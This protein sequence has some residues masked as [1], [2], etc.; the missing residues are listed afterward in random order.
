MGYDL[1]FEYSL[2]DIRAAHA[3]F[4]K[5]LFGF[6]W[7]VV[8]FVQ[9]FLF[10]SGVV[11]GVGVG[12]ALILGPLFDN[13]QAATL[14]STLFA[15]MF[16]YVVL[17]LNRLRMNH[18]FKYGLRDGKTRIVVSSEGIEE[19]AAGLKTV[20]SWDVFHSVQRSKR[21]VV[22]ARGNAFVAIPVRCF[23]SNEQAEEAYQQ[24]LVWKDTRTWA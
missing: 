3:V 5:I 24:M 2:K 19:T 9:G 22:A 12:G 18:Y 14:W 16:V 6:G 20:S 8:G 21:M 13:Q 17:G 15:L 23:E 10:F 4:G 11:F 7:R 1:E